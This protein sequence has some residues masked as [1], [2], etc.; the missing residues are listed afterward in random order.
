MSSFK[1]SP[2][3]ASVAKAGS[4]PGSKSPKHRGYRPDAAAPAPGK[5]KASRGGGPKK[6][7]W[8]ADERA[9]RGRAESR[10]RGEKQSRRT[11]GAS[12]SSRSQDR[13]RDWTPPN[14]RPAAK[15]RYGSAPAE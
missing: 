14:E 1:K 9:A 3:R 15:R 11:D 8:S 4:K 12:D 5:A 6:V 7:R 10:P 2:A 13:R